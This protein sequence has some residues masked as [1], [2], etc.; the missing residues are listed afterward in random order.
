MTCAC[1]YDVGVKYVCLVC[2]CGV[3]C[4]LYHLL[5]CLS[6]RVYVCVCVFVYLVY[7]V[8]GLWSVCLWGVLKVYW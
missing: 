1:I 6:D 2:A 4:G 3:W 5:C 8:Y 7:G